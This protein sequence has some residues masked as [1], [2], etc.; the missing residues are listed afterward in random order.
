M[1]ITEEFRD[2]IKHHLDKSPTHCPPAERAVIGALLLDND[3]YDSIADKL[4]PDDFHHRDHRAI[5]EGIQRLAS[6][7]SP[8]DAITLS[9][10]IGNQYLAKLVELARETPS[11]ANAAVYADMVREKATQ[12]RV[13]AVCDEIRNKAMSGKGSAAEL[14]DAATRGLLDLGAVT[15]DGPVSIRECL[16]AAVDRIDQ[17]CQSGDAITGLSSG[18]TDLDTI[19]AGFQPPT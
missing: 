15:A 2:Q 11:S 19:T 14:L 18:F 3:V 8:F 6:Q 9:E 17:R 4:S 10:T 16:T 7:G 12:R 13:I 5:F 1:T